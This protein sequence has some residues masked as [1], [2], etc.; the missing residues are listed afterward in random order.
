MMFDTI[1]LFVS[2]NLKED[3]SYR[4]SVPRRSPSLNVQV[5]PTIMLVHEQNARLSLKVWI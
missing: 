3:V 4:G 5:K 2:R 1:C